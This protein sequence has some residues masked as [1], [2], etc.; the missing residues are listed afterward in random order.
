LISPHQPF[1]QVQEMEWELTSVTAALSFEGDV[2]ETEDQ[3]NW[4]DFSYKTYSTPLELPFP[5]QVKKG[6]RVSQKVNLA[7]A[8]QAQAAVRSK[9]MSQQGPLEKMPFPNI[10]FERKQNSSH[11]TADDIEALRQIPFHHYRV[12]LHLSKPD[13][14]NE[15]NTAASEARQ[16]D[17]QLELV[18][19]FSSADGQLHQFI[20]EVSGYAAQVMCVLLLEEGKAATPPSLLYQA[21]ARIKAGL[22]HVN[23]GYGTD[24][25]FA[26]LNR[27][28]PEKDLPFDFISYSLNPQVH[29]SD[30]R[31]L[32]ENLAAQGDTIKAVQAFAPGKAIHVSPVTF[33]I[34]EGESPA[35]TTPT[36]EDGRMYT[37]LGAMWTLLTIKNLSGANCLTFYQA[38]SYRGLL[39]DIIPAANTSLYQVLKQLKSFGPKWI[40]IDDTGSQTFLVENE[41]GEQLQFSW[42]DSL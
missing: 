26:E 31:T 21:Y 24:G 15:L 25:F 9:A 34:R 28:R 13:W 35:L 32:L 37:A 40:M 1:K 10:G 8:P 11:L 14:K 22:P 18:V 12:V 7:F 36:D 3:R 38:K 16:I 4:T 6:D 42:Q 33:K 17:A 2:F 27:N 29:A 5:V 39:H 20:G 30:T 19:Y 23:I 41:T